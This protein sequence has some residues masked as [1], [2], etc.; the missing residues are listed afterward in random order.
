MSWMGTPDRDGG[1][2]ALVGVPVADACA[3]GYL[4]EAPVEDI[5]GVEVA[6]FVAELA[7]N[8]RLESG[9]CGVRSA[10]TGPS[11]AWR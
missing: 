8:Y 3:L 10:H 1:V 7:S 5:L 4:A 9:A 6:V 2:A 11:P